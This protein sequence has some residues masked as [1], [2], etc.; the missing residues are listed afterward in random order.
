M[1]TWTLSP[2]ISAQVFGFSE[3]LD[4]LSPMISAQVYGFTEDLDAFSDD[5]STGLQIH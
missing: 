2:L 3:D 5:F 4:A 1:K